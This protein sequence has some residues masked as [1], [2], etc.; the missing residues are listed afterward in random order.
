MLGIPC[1]KSELA[2]A[3]LKSMPLRDA[4]GEGGTSMFTNDAPR[5][6][7]R[8]SL[9]SLIGEDAYAGCLLVG[10]VEDEGMRGRNSDADVDSSVDD[11]E[12]ELCWGE[13]SSGL[14][15]GALAG[16]DGSPRCAAADGSGFTWSKS[17]TL[18]LD[19]QRLRG[20]VAAADLLRDATR[21]CFGGGGGA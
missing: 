6:A 2:M 14:L 3:N 1:V 12:L 13:V 15:K 5:R 16:D 4:W 8:L 11:S 19:L 20:P 9:S 18:L 10:E 7:A 17:T 21:F